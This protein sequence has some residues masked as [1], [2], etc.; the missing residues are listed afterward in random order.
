MKYEILNRWTGKAQFACDIPDAEA[1][2]L[3]EYRRKGRAVLEAKKAG[4]NLCG[5][6]LRGA[7]NADYAIACTRILPEGDLI[8][9]KKCVGDII[10]KVR[11]PAEAKRSHAFG[12]K[13]RAQFVDV[14]EIFGADKAISRHD[15]KTEYKIGERVTCDKW[16]EDFNNECSGGIHFFI[17]RLEAEN[18]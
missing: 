17:T 10:V 1:A 18:Y 11:I 14:L 12:R 13:C 9:W 4:A 2:M 7:K 5:A 16:D 15:E 6:D 8:G 3:D